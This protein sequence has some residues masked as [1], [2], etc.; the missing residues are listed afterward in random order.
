MGGGCHGARKMTQASSDDDGDM[1]MISLDF[2]LATEAHVMEMQEELS[3][4]YGEYVRMDGEHHLTA[5]EVRSVK[6]R[7][8][9][10]LEMLYDL[11]QRV[12]ELAIQINTRN[13]NL[14]AENLLLHER[15]KSLQQ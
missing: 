13:D 3:N 5:S 9:D 12:A 4:L 1:R 7:Q 6:L 15:L 10:V 2:S 14:R 8:R 11:Q